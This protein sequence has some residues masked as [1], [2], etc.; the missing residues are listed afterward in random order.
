MANGVIPTL[1]ELDRYRDYDTEALLRLPVPDSSKNFHNAIENSIVVTKEMLDKYK[2]DLSV[3]HKIL[4]DGRTNL[5]LSADIITEQRYIDLFND[6]INRLN[7]HQNSDRQGEFLEKGLRNVVVQG[8]LDILRDPIHQINLQKPVSMDVAKSAAEDSELG[9]DELYMTLDNPATKFKMQE[10][11][12]VGR[13]VIGVGATSLKGYF[14]ASMYYNLEVQRMRDIVRANPISKQDVNDELFKH[15]Q[16]LVFDSKFNTG[17][18][19]LRTLGNV[20]FKPLLKEIKNT[21]EWDEI[22]I[23]TTEVNKDLQSSLLNYIEDNKD[24]TSTLKFKELIT[25]L[26]TVSNTNDA[27]DS[28]STLISIATDFSSG[29]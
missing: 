29:R 14:A 22:I 24:G 27:P 23:T 21:T 18:T 1:S 11:N 20:N 17:V 26:Q 6:L 25:D 7:I 8:I 13:E 16:D 5:Q 10:Q 3:I 4:N 15:I 12:M 19:N 9:K 28:L 2:T